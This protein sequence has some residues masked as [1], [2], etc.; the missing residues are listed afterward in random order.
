MVESLSRA[1]NGMYQIR[2]ECP[3]CRAFIMWIPYRDS[4]V[5]KNIL[6]AF[7]YLDLDALSKLHDIAIIDNKEET[8]I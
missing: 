4:K 5:V 6:S 1:S 7:Y 3:K 8:I 2:G